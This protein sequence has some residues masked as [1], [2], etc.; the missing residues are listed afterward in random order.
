MNLVELDERD[1][2]REYSK[3]NP[4]ILQSFEWGVIKGCNWK[5]L[6]IGFKEDTR[7][8]SLATILTR[9][10]PIFGKTFGYIPRGLITNREKDIGNNLTLLNQFCKEKGLSFLLIDPDTNYKNND[11]NQIL[12]SLFEKAGYK[13]VGSPFQPGRTNI[14]ELS[15]GHENLMK[16]MR[17]KTRQYIRKAAR[18]DIEVREGREKDVDDFCK[19]AEQIGKKQGHYMQNCDYYRKIWKVYRQANRVKIFISQRKGVMLGAMMI[20]FNEKNV[21]EMYGGCSDEGNNLLANYALKWEVIKHFSSLG[22]KHYDQWGIDFRYPGLIQF[23][24][25]FGGKEIE[26]LPQHVKVFD[27]LGWNVYRII[28]LFKRTVS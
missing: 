20:L 8:L 3:L 4:S 1:Y 17:S 7:I 13:K 2:K 26:Y 22:Y 18:N 15:K 23:K 5:P 25:G 6:R 21:F 24:N 10:I 11:W 28:S 9:K 14:I 27:F 19:I 16:D 12:K